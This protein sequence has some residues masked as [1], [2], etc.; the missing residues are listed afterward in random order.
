MALPGRA[1]PVPCSRWRQVCSIQMC[2]TSS[3]RRLTSDTQLQWSVQTVF[4]CVERLF[5]FNRCATPPTAVGGGVMSTHAVSS[6]MCLPTSRICRSPC[7][8]DYSSGQAQKRTLAGGRVQSGSGCGNN[9]NGVHRVVQR[10]RIRRGRAPATGR[11]SPGG[12][13]TLHPARIPWID[14]SGARDESLGRSGDSSRGIGELGASRK[15]RSPSPLRSS[16]KFHRG[17]RKS[18]RQ[19]QKRRLRTPAHDVQYTLGRILERTARWRFQHTRVP[20]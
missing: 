19:W 1:T 18:P 8:V 11:P 16:P 10:W 12:T 9:E 13:H 20:S 5:E 7:E 2:S 15:E 4:P 3:G 14:H 17:G 6:E